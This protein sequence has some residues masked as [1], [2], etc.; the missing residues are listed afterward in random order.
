[1]TDETKNTN[2]SS[3]ETKKQIEEAVAQALAKAKEESEAK[4]NALMAKTRIENEKALAKA[5]EEASLTAEEKAKKEQEEEF[6]S[7]K[8]EL[9]RL[10]SELKS[11]TINEKL[12]E[13]QLPPFFK[14]DIRIINS[15]D[16]EIDKVVE[17]IAKEWKEVSSS[18][19]KGTPAPN[20]KGIGSA[21]T[22]AEKFKEFSKLR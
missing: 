6:K 4:L 3:E 15:N 7:A 16:E 17:T 2:A 10:K 22:K 11:K 1:M 19:S 13:R 14:N 12:N 9:E 20:G 18:G 5:K 8:E 21:D